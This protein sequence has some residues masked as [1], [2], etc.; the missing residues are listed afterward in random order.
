MPPKKTIAKATKATVKPKK[1]IAKSKVK[2]EPSDDGGGGGLSLAGKSVCFTSSSLGKLLIPRDIAT[3]AAVA[4]GARV[5]KTITKKTCVL[6]HNTKLNAQVL[7]RH[8]CAE[9][10]PDLQFWTE[11]KFREA[12]QPFFALPN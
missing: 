11:Q 5:A 8:F 3:A 6:V 2:A 4:S 9:S 1:V 10:M 12:V 7:R